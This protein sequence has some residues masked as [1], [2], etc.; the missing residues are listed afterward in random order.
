MFRSETSHD[1]LVQLAKYSLTHGQAPKAT[2]MMEEH[3]I[4]GFV[5]VYKRM[6]TE[7]ELKDF[8]GLRDFIHFFT[9]LSQVKSENDIISPEAIVQSLEHNFN[10]TAHFQVILRAFL[11]VVC[12]NTYIIKT[13]LYNIQIR[14]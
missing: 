14:N 12:L 6:M 2:D 10:G 13:I 8:F 7:P 5:K 9:Y 11:E 1:D 4:D 3:V